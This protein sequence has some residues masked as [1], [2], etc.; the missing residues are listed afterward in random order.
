MSETTLNKFEKLKK[1]NEVKVFELHYEGVDY[2]VKNPIAKTSEAEKIRA[3]FMEGSEEMTKE[4]T[5][6]F[7]KWVIVAS[8]HEKTP[9]G[10]LV[11]AFEDSE[12]NEVYEIITNQFVDAIRKLVFPENLAEVKAKNG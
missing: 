4:Q 9:E 8:L 7:S 3:K 10:E 11:R 2:F 1:A 5:Q 12:I 6:E